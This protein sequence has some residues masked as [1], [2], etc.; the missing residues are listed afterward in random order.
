MAV[1]PK[2]VASWGL[3]GGGT[4]QLIEGPVEIALMTSEELEVTLLADE[5]TVE[6]DDE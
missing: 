6:I 2:S 1:N 4:A 5:I 3:L